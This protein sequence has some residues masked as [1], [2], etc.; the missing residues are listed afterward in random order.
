MTYVMDNLVS[1]DD[2]VD[3]AQYIKNGYA[4]FTVP[5]M[6][7]QEQGQIVLY[8]SDEEMPGHEN[9]LKEYEDAARDRFDALF[10]R[11][12]TENKALVNTVIDKLYASQS[13]TKL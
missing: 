13:A 1:T 4:I 12:T 2:R 11:L 5:Q 7:G 9:A 3:A 6:F 10:K 8:K